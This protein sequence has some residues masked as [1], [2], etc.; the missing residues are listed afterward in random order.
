MPFLRDP[1][2]W[3]ARDTT[4]E[5][6]WARRRAAELRRREQE[7]RKLRVICHFFDSFDAS[8]EP[9]PSLP[10]L[11]G[12]PQWNGWPEYVVS[13]RQEHSVAGPLFERP[14]LLSRTNIRSSRFAKVRNLGRMCHDQRG[15]PEAKVLAR[16][17]PDPAVVSNRLS[18]IQQHPAPY[19]SGLHTAAAGQ[20]QARLARLARAEIRAMHST[21]EQL[22][23]ELDELCAT[24]DERAAW[25]M[26]D[27]SRQRSWPF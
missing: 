24:V 7:Q 18:S 5:A 6:R 17:T 13:S 12:H 8:R 11:P 9:M 26:T 16:Q 4:A 2:W 14:P 22:K 27:Q 20:E 21:L 23:V 15:I 1:G 25:S 3:K 19:S 10:L